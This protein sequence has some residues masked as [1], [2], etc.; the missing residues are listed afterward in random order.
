MPSSNISC[1]WYGSCCLLLTLTC[2]AQAE[3]WPQFRGPH[4]TGL[5][6]AKR[7]PTTWARDQHVAWKAD[8]PGQGW[9]QPVVWEKRIFVT[10]A[11]P[12]P[13]AD[14]AAQTAG[15]PARLVNLQADAADEPAAPADASDDRP[16]RPRRRRGAAKPFR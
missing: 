8:I 5:P 12:E 16:Q 1:R 4:G 15:V 13:A 6:E 11:V 7:L 14:A 10:T 3:N 9:S 2:A